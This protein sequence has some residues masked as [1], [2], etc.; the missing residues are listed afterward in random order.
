[1]DPCLTQRPVPIAQE[2]NAFPIWRKASAMLKA[3]EGDSQ[4]QAR[5]LSSGLASLSDEELAGLRRWLDQ[6]RPALESFTEGIAL[7][8]LRFPEEEA[9]EDLTRH[10]WDLVD[11][12]ALAKA[13]LLLAGFDCRDGDHASAARHAAE[14]LTAGGMIVEAGG[15]LIDYMVGTVVEQTAI[16]AMLSLVDA[17]LGSS[18]VKWL[19]ARLGKDPDPSEDARRAYAAEFRFSVERTRSLAVCLEDAQ[20]PAEAVAKWFVP[21][22]VE[23]YPSREEERK[24]LVDAI[25][26]IMAE[27]D[28]PLD[29]HATVVQLGAHRADF[30]K[31]VAGSWPACSDRVKAAYSAEGDMGQAILDMVDDP[32]GHVLRGLEK[33]PREGGNVLGRYSH[34]QYGGTRTMAEMM[35]RRPMLRRAAR[36]ALALHLFEMRQGRLPE[37]LDELVTAGILDSVPSDPFAEKPL[38]YSRERRRVW[39]V[40]PDETDDG[41]HDKPMTW[42]GKDYVLEVPGARRP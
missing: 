41:G 22:P 34:E 8:K 16:G 25:E 26:K 31:G 15:P 35:L 5:A 7:G 19:L 29:V 4:L 10:S 27:S 28:P 9:E 6:A 12:A 30:A 33:V 14:G 39:S 20:S 17:G 37:K 23:P 18:S 32:V 42:T 38:R 24:P 13:K 40:G 3:L 11:A 1:V 21:D 2:E 36:A